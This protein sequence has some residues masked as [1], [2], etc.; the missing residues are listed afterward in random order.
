MKKDYLNLSII[1]QG[2]LTGGLE[3]TGL[4]IINCPGGEL[5]G[6]GPLFP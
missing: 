4:L 1:N 3:T 2:L 6:P 5:L